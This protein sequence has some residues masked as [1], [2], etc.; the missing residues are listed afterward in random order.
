MEIFFAIFF[1]LLIIFLASRLLLKSRKNNLTNTSAE[2]EN[3]CIPIPIEAKLDLPAKM[4]L[5]KQYQVA[6]DGYQL[7]VKLW[8]EDSLLHQSGVERFEIGAERNLKN[9]LEI[10]NDSIKYPLIKQVE[11]KTPIFIV[12]W[13]RTGSTL[14]HN[15][16]AQD[17]RNF[18]PYFWELVYPVCVNNKVS[19]IED[20]NTRISLAREELDDFYASGFQDFRAI[21]EIR[22]EYPEECCHIFERLFTSRH[23]PIL[24]QQMDSY[25]EWL[26]NLSENEII[27]IYQMYNLEL[28]HKTYYRNLVETGSGEDN[29]EKQWVMKDQ[30][31]MLF[32]DGLLKTFPD[33]YIIHLYRDPAVVFASDSSGILMLSKIYYEKDDINIDGAAQR[34][35]SHM[36]ICKDRLLDFRSRVKE[37][38][39]RD[40]KDIFIDIDFNDV[41]K[42]PKE[43]IMKINKHIGKKTTD[44]QILGMNRYLSENPR[45]KHGEH[46]YRVED[47]GMSTEDV[48]E[49]FKDYIDKFMSS[50]SFS[51]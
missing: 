21:H 17:D 51:T 15:L 44:Q 43:C 49:H 3:L 41:V 11:I 25:N 14:L 2:D 23:I 12:S 16:L 29:P 36:K 18:T 40:E 9:L 50:T 45:Y 27:D 42:N 34:C 10:Y 28:Q 47:F 20:R 7:I 37:T 33:A 19:L 39:G 46:N 13:L 5:P 32:L 4:L 30:T 48:R 6:F 26:M 24:G 1:G 22:S 8:R 38:T 31:H 35:L